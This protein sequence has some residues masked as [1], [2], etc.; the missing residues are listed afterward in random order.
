MVPYHTAAVTEN[1]KSEKINPY[2]ARVEQLEK[3][4]AQIC[5]MI[6]ECEDDA[7]RERLDSEWRRL[8]KRMADIGSIAVANSPGDFAKMLRE[9]TD[10]W[11]KALKETGLAK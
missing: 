7:E 4:L 8:L 6:G 11:A 3:E 10:Q 9:E 5:K 1:D 2:K